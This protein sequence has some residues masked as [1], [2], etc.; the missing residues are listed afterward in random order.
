MN[1]RSGMIGRTWDCLC[2]M[3]VKISC[4]G[5]SG[6]GICAWLCIYPFRSVQIVVYD[7]GGYHMCVIINP[8]RD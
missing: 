3:S 2:D 1:G 4:P 7:V 8:E 5:D 6:G